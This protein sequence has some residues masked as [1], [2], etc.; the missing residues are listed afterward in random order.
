MDST[1]TILGM[2]VGSN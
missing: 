1:T 2:E